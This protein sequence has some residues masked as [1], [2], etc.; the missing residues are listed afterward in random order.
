MAQRRRTAAR[1]RVAQ[2]A[3]ASGSGEAWESLT[4]GQLMR[5]VALDYGNA[6]DAPHVFVRR[7]G[8]QYALTQAL[9]L[10]LCNPFHTVYSAWLERLDIVPRATRGGAHVC[11]LLLLEFDLP[12]HQPVHP[13]V[14]QRFL[15]AHDALRLRVA[16]LQT[17]SELRP[18]LCMD[19]WPPG[20][21]RQV[22]ALPPEEV[23]WLYHDE[24]QQAVAAASSASPEDLQWDPERADYVPAPASAASA[25]AA[26]AVRRRWDFVLG[27]HLYCPVRAR[28]PV[29][30]RL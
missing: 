5:E 26:P 28:A 6:F 3:Q 8:P 21:Q 18:P 12:T 25:T 1:Q 17:R 7:A 9:V 24:P 19:A 20:F 22:R 23:T 14:V 4:L 16:L 10:R 2:M 29:C 13:A 27:A 15:T 30:V 11:P